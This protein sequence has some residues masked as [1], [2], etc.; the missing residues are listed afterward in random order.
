MNI[1]NVRHIVSSAILVLLAACGST[2]QSNYYLLSAPGNAEQNSQ[3][4]S[5]GIGPIE[6]PEYL[7]R[8]GLV[9]H[10]D[11]NKLDIA[12]YERWAEPLASGVE[13]VIGL[14]LATLLGTQNIQ[15]YP[16]HR[17]DAPEYGVQVTIIML[18][19]TATTATL[20]AE[21]VVQ[22]PQQNTLL[23]R[24]ITQLH[25]ALPAGDVQPSQ[26]PATYS[27]LLFQLSEVIAASIT[28]DQASS[29]EPAT[30]AP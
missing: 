29:T 13:R 23:T 7:N 26:I 10:R 24:K 9:Y 20:V 2:P 8:N 22:K 18:D 4:P 3:T 11:G 21:W 27:D 5:L 19:T 1:I 14:N 15:S 25:M 17:N 28:A 12:S 30:S 16:W 6:I